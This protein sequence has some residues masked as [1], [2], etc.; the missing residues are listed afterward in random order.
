[1]SQGGISVGA[2]S[3]APMNAGGL[4]DR[5]N[6]YGQGKDENSRFNLHN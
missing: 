5:A 1:M 3:A 2:I 6:F 4:Y